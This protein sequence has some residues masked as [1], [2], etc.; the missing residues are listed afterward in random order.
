MVNITFDCGGGDSVI[1]SGQIVYGTKFADKRYNQYSMRT[2]DGSLVAYD[3]GL[4]V[5]AGEIIIKN[6]SYADGELLRTWLH[7]KAIFQ[8]NKFDITTPDDVDLGEGKGDDIIDANFNGN[9]DSNVFQYTVPGLYKIVFPYTYV[10][11]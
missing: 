8:F 1:F 11:S 7:E 4:N 3:T 2:A 6:V 5:V 9:D 10:R